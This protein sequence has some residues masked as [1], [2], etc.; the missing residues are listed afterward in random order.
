MTYWLRH[1]KTN[2]DNDTFTEMTIPIMTTNI[3]FDT[4]PIL[5]RHRFWHETDYDINTGLDTNT[6]FDTN[7]DL[8]L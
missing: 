4:I 5:T 7:T 6:G 2:I 1:N 8:D 3:D